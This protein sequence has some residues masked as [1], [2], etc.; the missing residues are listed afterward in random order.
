MKSA[1]YC[2][3]FF[4][5]KT[6][7]QVD[8]SLR[9]LAR[10]AYDNVPFYSRTWSEAHVDPADVR[11]VEDLRRLPVV[12]KDNLLA[13]GA[14]DR[15]HRQSLTGNTVSRLTSGTSGAI[16]EVRMSRAELRFR[17][18]SF[19]H[20][21]WCDTGCRIP[22][23][24]VHAGVWFPK[25]SRSAVQRHLSPFGPVIRISRQLPIERQIEVIADSSPTVLTGCPSFLVTL[26]TAVGELPRARIHPKLVMTRGETLS[27]A[28]RQALKRTFLTRITDYYS[29]EEAGLVAWQCP[30]SADI[31]HVST[32]N[33]ILEV[34]DT[35]GNPCAPE[36]DGAVVVT[37]LFNHTMP[38]IRYSLGDYTSI[39]QRVPVSCRCDPD[40]LS[41]RPPA[42]RSDDFILLPNGQRLSP[43]IIA[44]LVYDASAVE[45]TGSPFF[46]SVRDYQ[47]L[48]SSPDFIIFS[49]LTQLRIPDR[50]ASLLAEGCKEL[51]PSLRCEVR[52]VEELDQETSGK[53]RRIV[54]HARRD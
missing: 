23:T 20:R 49:Y 19:F 43:R 46:E 2:V 12:T 33:C 30:T 3:R 10:T 4:P 17:Q 7:R 15:M 11:E 34:L 45:G 50:V 21:L 38:L 9:L 26:A 6:A 29:C 41:I 35:M 53:Q 54:S 48:Q 18:Y 36:D 22:M 40:L 37:N 47:V 31:M 42:G 8:T 25:E 16:L 24:T 5:H 52:A 32:A 14:S 39:A 51:H 28:N 44:D 1:R 27:P 13:R